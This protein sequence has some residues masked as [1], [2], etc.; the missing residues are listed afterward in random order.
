[1]DNINLNQL[2]G[3]Y[4]VNIPKSVQHQV[5]PPPNP[6]TQAPKTATPSFEQTTANLQASA[7]GGA[8]NAGYVREMMKLPQNFNALLYIVQKDMTNAQLQ[9]MLN[10]NLM[11]SRNLSQTQA[12]IL[13]QLQGLNFSESSQV[14]SI[15]QTLL[16]QLE[17]A[18]KKLPISASGM[19]NIADIANLIKMNGKD[20]ITQIIINMAN[21]SKNGITDVSQMKDA[22]KLIN[23]SIAVAGQKDNAQTL[24]M[25]ML[26]YL[27]WLPL[28]EGVDF[29]LEIQ[30]KD[31]KSLDNSMLVVRVQTVHYGEIVAVLT[32]E[33]ANAVNIDIQCSETFPRDELS[34]RLEG[35]N[36][37]AMSSINYTE[38][39]NDNSK[40]EK[41]QATIN[42]S[43]TNEI[44]P[45]LLLYAHLIIR[46]V[47]EMDKNA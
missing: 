13:A 37:S 2:K 34:L 28:Q 4:L 3:R 46:N 42:M 32:L 33:K 15:N 38:K 8:E 43:N 19:I 44:N 9:A 22:A 17:T 27:P 5:A 47:V 10:K 16:S 14:A 12:Q 39:S 25:L 6:V 40:A 21:A 45:Y 7:M 18:L 24:K 30:A 23:A 35:E 1:M 11:A 20:A 29:E 36:Y 41:A 26:L 31:E